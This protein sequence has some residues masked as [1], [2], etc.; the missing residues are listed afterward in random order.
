MVFS[1]MGTIQINDNALTYEQTI[2]DV[3]LDLEIHF[4]SQ[5]TGKN[6]QSN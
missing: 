6:V 2:I 4:V 1:D 3:D 5:N